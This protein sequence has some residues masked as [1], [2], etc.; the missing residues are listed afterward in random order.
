MHFSLT[1]AEPR[2]KFFFCSQLVNMAITPE[3]SGICKSGLAEN[4]TN[5]MV[6]FQR[7]SLSIHLWSVSKNVNDVL[8]VIFYFWHTGPSCSKHCSLNEL[9]SGQNVN[10]SSKYYI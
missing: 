6:D 1:K 7:V 8:S 2:P 3:A 10:C 4:P 5:S 9:I